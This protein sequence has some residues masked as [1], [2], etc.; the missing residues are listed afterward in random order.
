MAESN[1]DALILEG[2]PRSTHTDD[3]DFIRLARESVIGY[4]H[5]LA[6]NE[7]RVLRAEEYI[8]TVPRPLA[9]APHLGVWFSAR[10]DALCIR[11][12][13]LLV[14][15]EIKTGNAVEPPGILATLPSVFIYHHVADWA[16]SPAHGLEVV[17][18]LPHRGESTHVRIGE[19][20]I[21]TGRAFVREMVI[22]LDARA[23][24]PRTGPKCAYCQC[25]DT[26]PAHRRMAKSSTPF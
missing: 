1:P 14:A 3:E 22:A 23:F 20:E 25:V 11:S 17:R 15:I 12:D 7:L 13:G 6:V 19:S 2:C 10:I 8:R 16:F 5:F 24:A 21:S 9:G 26:C 18:L 4:R